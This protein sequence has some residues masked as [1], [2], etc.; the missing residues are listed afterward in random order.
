MNCK[1]VEI[2]KPKYRLGHPE[3]YL[4]ILLII[5]FDRIKVSRKTFHLVLKEASKKLHWYKVLLVFLPT[6]QSCPERNDRRVSEFWTI[7]TIYVMASI[8]ILGFIINTHKTSCFFVF[9]KALKRNTVVT[10]F[11]QD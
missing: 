2:F 7:G 4:F 8:G 6:N 10:N 1:A 9:T 5:F 11:V 3:N